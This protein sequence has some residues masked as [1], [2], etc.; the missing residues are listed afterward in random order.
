MLD[1]T[2]RFILHH[3]FLVMLGAV[4]LLGAGAIAWINL[5]ID[6]FPDVTNVQVMILTRCTGLAPEEVERLITY[7]IE[8]E[9]G[10]LPN[11]K[12]VRSLS[13]S[14][15]SQVVVIF[16]DDVDTY[17]ARNLVFE[18]LAGAR[19]NLPPELEDFVKRVRQKARQP[20]CVG[21]GIS[22]PEQARRVAGVADGVIIGSHFI[23]LMEED[24]TLSSLRASTSSLR[25]ALDSNK[26]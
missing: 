20:L 24:A 25:K 11:V 21:F 3:R 23:R 2:L 13:Q 12:L 16:E 8:T 14:G 26:G 6:A 18:R 17:F 19:E 7:P 22:T 4:I 15:L 5:P 10:G 1:T 9:M